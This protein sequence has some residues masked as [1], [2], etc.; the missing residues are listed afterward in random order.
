MTESI[1]K[2]LFLA[3]KKKKNANFVEQSSGYFR[4]KLLNHYRHSKNKIHASN[5]PGIHLLYSAVCVSYGPSD[6]LTLTSNDDTTTAFFIVRGTH[7][8]SRGK[9]PA[10]RQNGS[11]VPSLR[12]VVLRCLFVPVEL[13]LFRYDCVPRTTKHRVAPRFFFSGAHVE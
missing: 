2:V 8:M 7:V 4:T 10:R 3:K 1:D 6:D 9:T 5:A 13:L 11:R 12:C